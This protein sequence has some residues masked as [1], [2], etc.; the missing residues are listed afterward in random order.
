MTLSSS[1]KIGA[2]KLVFSVA[3][4]SM[5]CLGLVQRVTTNTEDDLQCGMAR[6]TMAL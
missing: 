4:L 6:V 3:E 1:G 2:Q 5:C